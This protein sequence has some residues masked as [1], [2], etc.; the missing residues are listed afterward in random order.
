MAKTFSTMNFRRFNKKIGLKNLNFLSE[1][2]TFSFGTRTFLMP[3]SLA[4]LQQ[5]S[6][7]LGMEAQC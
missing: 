4:S 1:K 6:K 5:T 3:Y 2:T 7:T